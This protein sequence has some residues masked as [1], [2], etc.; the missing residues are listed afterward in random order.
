MFKARFNIKLLTTA[1]LFTAVVIVFTHLPQETIPPLLQKGGFDT[2]QHFLAYGVITYLF[3]ITLKTS[4]TMLSALLL[5][6]VVSAI[7]A[8]DELTQP[9]VGRTASVTD[10]VA[11]IV[12]MLA[13]L[14]FVTVRGRRFQ[15]PES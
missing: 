1:I 11:D 3:L 8:F 12:G 6:F 7:G 2:L 4:P 14:C 15:R 9:F 13:A 5:F 10:L